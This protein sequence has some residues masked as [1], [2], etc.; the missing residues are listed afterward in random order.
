MIY[1][2]L[3]RPCAGRPYCLRLALGGRW[4]GVPHGLPAS[5]W[6]PGRVERKQ[7]RCLARPDLRWAETYAACGESQ[8]K[9]R[10]LLFSEEKNQKTFR[11]LSRPSK[12]AQTPEFAK[13][14]C[15]LSSEKKAFP[16]FVSITRHCNV[17]R[18]ASACTRNAGVAASARRRSRA[19]LVLT[20]T[21]VAAGRTWVFC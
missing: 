19:R 17:R 3:G 15:F 13:V 7:A 1:S 18:A 4:A 21:A 9:V 5:P 14:F 11:M 12:A 10:K 2:C 16:Y 6:R 20:C 8:G